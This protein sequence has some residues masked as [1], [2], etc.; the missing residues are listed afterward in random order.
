MIVPSSGSAAEF[1]PANEPK[2]A[3]VDDLKNVRRSIS[4]MVPSRTA[5]TEEAQSQIFVPRSAQT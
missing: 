2:A 4:L 1:R 5:L 3:A